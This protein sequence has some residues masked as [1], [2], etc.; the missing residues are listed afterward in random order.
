[1]TRA[2]LKLPV[3]AAVSRSGLCYRSV[4]RIDLH[5]GTLCIKDTAAMQFGLYWL[6]GISIMFQS[7]T[8]ETFGIPGPK[9]TMGTNSASTGMSR[10]NRQLVRKVSLREFG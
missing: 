8:M 10:N 4:E 9:S 7:L 3:F 6:R 5:L 2:R 1:M